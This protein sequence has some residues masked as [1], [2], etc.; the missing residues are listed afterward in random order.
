MQLSENGRLSTVDPNELIYVDLNERERFLLRCGMVEWGGP[1]RCTEEMAVALGFASVQS[2]FDDTDRLI[3]ALDSKQ[4][5]SRLDWLRVLLATEVVFASNTLGSGADWSITTG[6]PDDETIQL[7]RAVQ[8]TLTGKVVG[9]VGH[10]FGTRPLREDGTSIE[11]WSTGRT[12]DVPA[13]VLGVVS[14]P[15]ELS[16]VVQAMRSD[17]SRAKLSPRTW[18]MRGR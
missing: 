15:S 14:T 13:S 5:L 1:A 12:A 7:L 9:L 2:L 17:L 3:R 16:K 6:L 18:C 4:P 10:G 8:R 11:R